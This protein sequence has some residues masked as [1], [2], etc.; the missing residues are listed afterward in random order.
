MHGEEIIIDI[1][2]A[3]NVKVE[4]KNIQGPHCMQLTA[5]IEEALGATQKVTKKPEFHRTAALGRKVRG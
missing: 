5:E 4:G 2:E 1:D 3:G